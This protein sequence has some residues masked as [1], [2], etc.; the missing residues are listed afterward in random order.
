MWNVMKRCVHTCIR[1]VSCGLVIDRK[2]L[3]V[4]RG[5]GWVVCHVASKISGT[6]CPVFVEKVDLEVFDLCLWLRLECRERMS[7]KAEK[8][9]SS[10]LVVPL[11]T[12]LDVVVDGVYKHAELGPAPPSIVTY[13]LAYKHKKHAMYER[14]VLDKIRFLPIRSTSDPSRDRDFSKALSA[15]AKREI[16][17][18]DRDLDDSKSFLARFNKP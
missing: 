12:D 10:E 3:C 5:R 18:L 1:L 11:D 8:S 7:C 16:G 2:P 14:S 15:V 17:R 4:R 13:L 6:L 9:R